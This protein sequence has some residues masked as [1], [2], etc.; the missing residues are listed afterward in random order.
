MY[1]GPTPSPGIKPGSKNAEATER[2][3]RSDNPRIVSNSENGDT[4][5]RAARSETPGP[6]P[7]PGIVSNSENGDTTERAAISDT[8]GPTPT[9]GNADLIAVVNTKGIIRALS[10][11]PVRQQKMNRK[12]KAETSVIVT[13]SPY[14]K[15]LEDKERV[16]PVRATAGPGEYLGV[17][18]KPKAST[19]NKK[20]QTVLGSPPCVCRCL[21]CDELY[22]EPPNEDWMQC[23]ACKCW[24]HVNRGDEEPD[25]CDLCI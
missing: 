13:S 2:P 25:T 1:A 11:L 21:Y 5:E 8:P 7:S 20:K 6:T 14:K 15:L 19:T 23:I 3:T 10:P 12:R 22:V 9:S 18:R 24:Y 17:R 16:A 4:T